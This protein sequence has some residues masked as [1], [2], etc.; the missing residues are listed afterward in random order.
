MITTIY[1]HYL[2]PTEGAV[3]YRKNLYKLSKFTQDL[4]WFPS[5]FFLLFSSAAPLAAKFASLGFVSKKFPRTEM[6]PES[7]FFS[8]FVALLFPSPFFLSLCVFR[9]SELILLLKIQAPVILAPLPHHCSRQ[10]PTHSSLHF[11]P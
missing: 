8:H 7:T 10:F 2:Y 3:I 6:S 11:F 4:Y 1:L 5:N 9:S